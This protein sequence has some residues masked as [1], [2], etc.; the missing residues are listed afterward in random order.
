MSRQA[1]PSPLNIFDFFNWFIKRKE[2][3]TTSFCS[4]I[5]MRGTPLYP[6]IREGSLLYNRMAF[7]MFLTTDRTLKSSYQ[8][9]KMGG[10]MLA[11]P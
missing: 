11:T 8:L 4:S 2:F 9:T 5:D 6:P 3:L 10:G 1:F 7:V